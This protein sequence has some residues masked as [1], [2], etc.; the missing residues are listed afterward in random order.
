MPSILIERLSEKE[1]EK[2]DIKKAKGQYNSWKEMLLD[3][4]DIED[5]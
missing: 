2:L 1:K 4:A 3:L 5:D